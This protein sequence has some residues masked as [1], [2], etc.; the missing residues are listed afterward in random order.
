M[1]I[2]T[3]SKVMSAFTKMTKYAKAEKSTHRQS[4]RMHW[5]GERCRLTLSNMLGEIHA[6]IPLED[7]IY[8]HD[9]IEAVITFDALKVLFSGQEAVFKRSKTVP[10]P[11]WSL[12]DGSISFS[13]DTG[14]I[15]IDLL[16]LSEFT[17]NRFRGTAVAN[18]SHDAVAYNR[19]P[20]GL[21]KAIHAAL[22]FAAKDTGRSALNSVFVGIEGSVVATDGHR[23]CVSSIGDSHLLE[24][25]LIP[26]NPLDAI[27][28]FR[29][30]RLISS[31]EARSCLRASVYGNLSIS[32]LGQ[33]WSAEIPYYEDGTDRGEFPKWEQVVPSTS[34]AKAQTGFSVQDIVGISK[35]I[36]GLHESI[37]ESCKAAGKDANGRWIET[38]P[39]FK[40]H[41]LRLSSNGGPLHWEY[42]VESM[43]I[44]GDIGE[45]QNQVG[46]F[47]LGVNFEYLLDA[48]KY[49][50]SDP[51]VMLTKDSLSPILFCTE[52]S[53]SVERM[54]VVMPLRLA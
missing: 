13:S 52:D 53:A 39:S 35:E 46:E 32:F 50:H 48:A 40:G 28:G 7:E 15:S 14:N 24:A 23:L 4:V 49:I 21:P 30:D 29:L 45:V 12:L 51:V 5:I 41:P 18:E 27:C 37:K 22:P 54:C 16:P 26:R 11:T 47:L 6:E 33:N 34:E 38:P 2:V 43:K 25:I 8:L 9:D 19:L 36:K 44:S 10:V 31:G 20:E 1:S 17:E 42:R 3:L